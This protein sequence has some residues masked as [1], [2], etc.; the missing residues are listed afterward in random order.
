MSE[1]ESAQ[2]AVE[3]AVEGMTCANCAAR[4]EKALNEVE[5]VE[6][7]VNFA[8]EKAYARYW[9][10]RA[11]VDQ[12]I[13]TVAQLGRYR[14]AVSTP[15]TREKEKA[16]RLAVY[17]RELK[18]FVMSAALTL[19]LLAQMFIMFGSGSHDELLP[20]WLQLVLATPV[21][22]WVGSR[23]YVGAW[24]SLKSGNGNMDVLVALGTSMAWLFSAVVTVVG[25]HHLHVYFEASAAVITL[26]LLG[27]ILEA[28]A[29]AR[30][31]SAIES[32]IGLQPRTA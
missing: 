26:V 32:L 3:L 1:A 29:K 14:A 17:Q 23:F 2:L 13:A 6:A 8:N 10:E 27:K 20:R 18:V 11:N 4:I 15:D 28:R 21:Q 12:L 31:S 19:P 25:L 7:V 22:F 16:E 24:Y 9:P 30:A 5:G